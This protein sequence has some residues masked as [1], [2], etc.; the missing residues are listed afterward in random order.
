[1]IQNNNNI[2]LTAAEESGIKNLHSAIA[3]TIG[4]DRFTISIEPR[5]EIFKEEICLMLDLP[6][7][8]EDGEKI[9]RLYMALKRNGGF[10]LEYFQLAECISDNKGCIAANEINLNLIRLPVK[11]IYSE[12]EEGFYISSVFYNPEDIIEVLNSVL[13]ALEYLIVLEKFL[14]G[15]ATDMEIEQAFDAIVAGGDHINPL[16]FEDFNLVK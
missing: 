11:C 13:L 3:K 6:I 15:K 7:R 4:E 1:M 12:N 14:K 16:K 8:P 2:Q 5:E 10:Y 9:S